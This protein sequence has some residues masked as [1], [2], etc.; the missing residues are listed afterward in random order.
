MITCGFFKNRWVCINIAGVGEY[1]D[2][3]IF[4]PFF[5]V[6]VF[7]FDEVVLSFGIKR[8]HDSVELLVVPLE[9]RGDSCT[10]RKPL[11]RSHGKI[12]VE[13]DLLR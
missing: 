9:F 8:C 2:E 6:T 7:V 11:V 1:F 12:L 10:T 4:F 13:L 5:V 3:F